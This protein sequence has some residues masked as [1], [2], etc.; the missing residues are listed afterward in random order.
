MTDPTAAALAA[1]ISAAVP[2][3]DPAKVRHTADDLLSA[4]AANGVHL[5]D[6]DTLAAAWRA[7]ANDHDWHAVG[8]DEAE[9]GHPDKEWD[10]CDAL[11]V[12]DWYSRLAARSHRRRLRGRQR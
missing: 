10:G 2:D 5:I 11:C 7:H 12:D 4:L 6:R 9:F 8:Y 3:A 1:A